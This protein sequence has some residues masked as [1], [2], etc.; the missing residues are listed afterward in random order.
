MKMKLILGC[1]VAALFA[2]TAG[3]QQLTDSGAN[4]PGAGVI[5]SQLNYATPLGGGWGG[6]AGQPTEDYVNND[7]PPGQAFTLSANG[8][9]AGIAFMGVGDL[10]SNGENGNAGGD[11]SGLPLSIQIGTIAPDG[12][13]TALDTESMVWPAGTT[14]AIESDWFT[15]GLAHPQN[16]TAGTLYYYSIGCTPTDTYWFGFSHSLGG[17][18]LDPTHFAFGSGPTSGLVPMNPG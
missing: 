15:I 11:I 5:Q 4:A 6:G 7:G 16:L 10:G 17:G 12:T 9:V 1:I 3:A 2:F 18:A 8:T 13:M 14:T